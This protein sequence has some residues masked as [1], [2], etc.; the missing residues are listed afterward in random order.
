V[1]S[2]RAMTNILSHLLEDFTHCFRET[3]FALLFDLSGIASGMLLYTYLSGIE[4]AI[5]FV[6]ILYPGILSVRGVVNGIFAGNLSTGLH[7]GTVE[8]SIRKLSDRLKELYALVMT[9]TLLGALLMAALASVVS[10][11]VFPITPRITLDIVLVT[12]TTLDISLLIVSPLTVV[13]AFY[14]F[15]AGLDPD[16]ILYPVISTLADLIV[17]GCYV[18]VIELLYVS[19]GRTLLNGFIILFT[20]AQIIVFYVHIKERFF[21]KQLRECVVTIILVTIISS[22][23]GLFLDKVGQRLGEW[24]EVY[25]VYPALIDTVGDVGSIV[26]SIIST[27]LHIGGL[28]PSL[29]IIPG[30]SGIILGI[31]IASLVVFI[32]YSF[33]TIM[34]AGQF[35]VIAVVEIM[36]LL[37]I[38]NIFAIIAIV[39]VALTVSILTF[40]VGLNPDNFVNP[41]VSTVADV[42]ATISLYLAFL[43]I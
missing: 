2:P 38:S 9:L 23:T 7:L 39:A 30:S 24:T 11:K 34:I 35:S 25:T 22:L 40:K 32:I 41:M 6:L 19:V 26:G 27:Q 17:T 3:L 33:V 36:K 10:L 43:V 16:K 12:L 15:K 18:V 14:S 8:P 29:H 42:V 5:P 1:A 31:W 20:S 13:V 37:L 28:K 4:K 21:K